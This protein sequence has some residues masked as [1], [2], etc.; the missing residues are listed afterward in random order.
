MVKKLVSGHGNEGS[1]PSNDILY[2]VLNDYNMIT[3]V[4][5]DWNMTICVLND[6]KM[7]TFFILKCKSTWTLHI[8][9][10]DMRQHHVMSSCLSKLF[11]MTLMTIVI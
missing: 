8:V 3:C 11:G 6:Y 7:I 9:V 2:L 1:I 10:L 4:I 5:N